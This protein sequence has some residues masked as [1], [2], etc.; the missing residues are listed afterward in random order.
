MKRGA[1][2]SRTGGR[3]G[4]EGWMVGQE[5]RRKEEEG[6]APHVEATSSDEAV[7]LVVGRVDANGAA[8]DVEGTHAV[9]A[10]G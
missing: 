2:G 5:C 9:S 1:D 3:G 4:R 6:S 8:T 10:E 7:G